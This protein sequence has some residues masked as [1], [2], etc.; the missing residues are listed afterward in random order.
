VKVFTE[1]MSVVIL[2]EEDEAADLVDHFRGLN[3]T[4]PK[5]VGEILDELE[6]WLDDA[7]VEFAGD[8]AQV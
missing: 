1:S 5:V 4:E 7:D 6:D 8:A 3:M 2:L